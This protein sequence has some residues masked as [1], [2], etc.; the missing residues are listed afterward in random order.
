MGNQS[1]FINHGDQGKENLRS[2]N[3]LT[4]GRYKIGFYAERDIEMGEE[5]FFD[6]DGEGELYKNYKD[7]YPFIN[8]KAKNR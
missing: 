4:Q 1:R 8:S 7:K 2:E 5:L 6:Y 3:I